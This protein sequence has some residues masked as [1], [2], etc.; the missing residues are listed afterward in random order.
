MGNFWILR[1]WDRKYSVSS[2]SHILVLFLF[3]FNLPL[4]NILITMPS[5]TYFGPGAFSSIQ[6]KSIHFT[7]LHFVSIHSIQFQFS[8]NLLNSNSEKSQNF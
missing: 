8:Q 1:M 2:F 5:I 3:Y 7:L 4:C 6:F